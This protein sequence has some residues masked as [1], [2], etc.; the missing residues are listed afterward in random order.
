MTTELSGKCGNGALDLR[1]SSKT[2]KP[3]AISEKSRFH[4]TLKRVK[5]RDEG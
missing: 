3:E 4:L 2:D 1:Y 5:R